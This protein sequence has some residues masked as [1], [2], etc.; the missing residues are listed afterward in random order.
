MTDKINNAFQ[1]ALGNA[2]ESVGKAVGSD[3]LSAE[4]A[5]QRAQA[6]TRNAANTTGQQAYGAADNIAGRAKSA[7]GAAT[8]NNKMEAQGH[9]QD[10]AGDVRRAVNQ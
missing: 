4:G 5:A 9:L 7:V 3:Q 1:S 6:E 2:K 8:G 10:G